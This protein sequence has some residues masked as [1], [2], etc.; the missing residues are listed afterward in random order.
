MVE[1]PA[2]MLVPV[3]VKSATP[4]SVFDDCSDPLLDRV[5]TSEPL[6]VAGNEE[7]TLVLEEIG[8]I[9]TVWM[10]A[11]AFPLF[12]TW[13]SN[14]FAVS[15]AE[16]IVAFV[17]VSSTKAVHHVCPSR[18]VFDPT[19]TEVDVTALGGSAVAFAVALIMNCG[20]VEFPEL[21]TKVL[22][23]MIAC[24]VP[25]ALTCVFC[26]ICAVMLPEEIVA[27]Y[28]WLLYVTVPEVMLIRAWS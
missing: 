13:R 7:V 25:E 1:D 8:V 21:M 3:A 12:C 9:I 26:C 11:V 20:D 22:R 23:S 27:T 4:C 24:A 17:L 10:S 28:C 18:L 19:L 14:E 5:N 15:V 16:V 2:S 6:R